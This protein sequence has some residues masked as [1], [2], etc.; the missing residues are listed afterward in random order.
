[1]LDRWTDRLY[2]CFQCGGM[3]KVCKEITRLWARHCL[4]L[5]FNLKPLEFQKNWICLICQQ[6][7][8]LAASAKLTKL[9]RFLRFGFVPGAAVEV[10]LEKSCTYPCRAGRGARKKCTKTR[11]FCSNGFILFFVVLSYYGYPVYPVRPQEVKVA[12]TNLEV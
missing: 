7:V 11:G 8:A 9:L 5:A 10:L 4:H 3:L 12:C 1:M 2:C 6:F